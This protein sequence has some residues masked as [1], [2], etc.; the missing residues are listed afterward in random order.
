MAIKDP[1]KEWLDVQLSGDEEDDEVENGT[2]SFVNAKKAGFWECIKTIDEDENEKLLQDE[3]AAEYYY[4][5][6]FL[7]IISGIEK[8]KQGSWMY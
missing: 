6:M 8:V 1:Q 7:D 2:T 3:A 5:P 4:G